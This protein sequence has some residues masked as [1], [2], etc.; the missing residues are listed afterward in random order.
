MMT[1][2]LLEQS[3]DLSS[4][5]RYLRDI[6]HQERLVMPGDSLRLTQYYGFMFGP[7]FHRMI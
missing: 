2:K 5:Q 1:G 7:A 3:T 6:I 4:D